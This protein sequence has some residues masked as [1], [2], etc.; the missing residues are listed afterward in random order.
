MTSQN[1]QESGRTEIIPRGAV[2]EDVRRRAIEVMR[3]EGLEAKDLRVREG[4]A[5]QTAER[6]LWEEGYVAK[7]ST[8]RKM[9]QALGMGLE[10]L[11]AGEGTPARSRPIGDFL[12]TLQRC[13]ELDQALTRSI[14]ELDPSNPQI[15]EIYLDVASGRAARLGLDLRSFLEELASEKARE[16]LVETLPSPLLRVGVEGAIRELRFKFGSESIPIEDPELLWDCTCLPDQPENE[17]CPV[18][19]VDDRLEELFGGAGVGIQAAG[20][21]THWRSLGNLWP[22]SIDSFLFVERAGEFFEGRPTPRSILDLG[23]GTGFLGIALASA[24][25]ETVETLTLSDWLSA[26]Y[27]YG[28]VNA[29]RNLP[30]SIDVQPR[31]GLGSTWMPRALQERYDLLV[32]NPPYLPLLEGAK[33]N[34]HAT[35]AGTQLLEYVI[36]HG[37]DLAKTTILQF[38]EMALP[39]ASAAAS[40]AGRSLQEIGAPRQVPF[41]VPPALVQPDYMERLLETQRI[42][43]SDGLR[44]QYTHDLRTYLIE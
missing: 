32:C 39:E 10:E 18:H 44:H 11:L 21:T 9:A 41:R 19:S 43:N 17:D 42:A 12:T 37:P 22:P 26:P 28:I 30:E 6:F 33:L 38:S 7:P 2:P 34:M 13:C 14:R 3:R 29:A 31:L 25:R 16:I 1:P 27:L 23:S 4:P 20:I 36:A 15:E 8:Y 40:R 35:V 5:K 24:W